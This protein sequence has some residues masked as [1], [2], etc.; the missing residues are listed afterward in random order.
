VHKRWLYFL[1]RDLTATAFPLALAADDLTL[2]EG[3]QAVS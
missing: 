3:A 1:E 2:E